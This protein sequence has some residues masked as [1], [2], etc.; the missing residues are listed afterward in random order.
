MIKTS[1]FTWRFPFFSGTNSSKLIRVHLCLLQAGLCRFL[2]VIFVG[3]SCPNPS[4]SISNIKYS[5]YL[6]SFGWGCGWLCLTKKKKP[7]GKFQYFILLQWRKPSRLVSSTYAK[8]KGWVHSPPI[9]T[10]FT[11]WCLSWL[12]LVYSIVFNEGQKSG[13]SSHPSN[14]HYW[15]S[16]REVCYSCCS[17][18][19]VNCYAFRW[20]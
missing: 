3:E 5:N 14:F 1:E 19:W 15:C 10:L 2:Q 6:P 17:S 12:S 16:G 7:S 18:G 4:L 9:A 8:P 13:P 20:S 11:E